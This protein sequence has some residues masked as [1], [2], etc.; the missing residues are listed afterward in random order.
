M[1]EHPCFDSEAHERIGRVHLPVAPRCNIHCRFCERVVCAS[2]C[3]QHPGW[4]RKLLTPSEAMELVR[5]LVRAHPAEPF[6]VGVAGPGEPLANAATLQVLRQV[7]EVFPS[8]LKC[9]STNGLL[10]EQSLPELLKAGVRTLTVTVNAPD[11]AIGQH[12]YAW[13]RHQGKTLRGVEAAELLIA[14]QTRGIEMALRAGLAVKVNTVLIP[15]IN[16]QHVV[17]LARRL[18]SLGVHLMNIMPL[19]PGGAMANRRAP[20][21]QELQL[22]R[23]SCGQVIWQF[24]K[25][26]QCSADVVCF[27]GLKAPSCLLS[28]P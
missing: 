16:D 27:P 22:A 25:C 21:R 18:A 5:R 4:A 8:L 11:S 13:V 7:H 20:T 17:R 2:Q 3:E 1:R 26:R 9:V 23:S 28:A 15:G 10:L 24:D 19:I 14:C 6:V 12:I